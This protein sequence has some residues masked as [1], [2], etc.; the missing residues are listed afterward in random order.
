MTIKMYWIKCLKFLLIIYN[1]NNYK[2]NKKYY[3]RNYN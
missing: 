1:Q 3:N 2:E